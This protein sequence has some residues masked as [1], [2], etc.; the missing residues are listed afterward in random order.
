MF[1]TKSRGAEETKNERDEQDENDHGPVVGHGAV[2]VMLNMASQRQ[3][4][5]RWRSR[6]PKRANAWHQ[7]VPVLRSVVGWDSGASGADSRNGVVQA[8]AE[9]KHQEDAGNEVARSSASEGCA[10]HGSLAREHRD[11]HGAGDDRD[12]TS[13]PANP[14]CALLRPMASETKPTQMF[15]AIAATLFQV[16]RVTD[17]GG[18]EAIALEPGRNPGVHA[19]DAEL[20]NEVGGPDSAGGDDELAGEQ[21]RGAGLGGLGRNDQ[22][23]GIEVNVDVTRGLD[24]LLE[25]SDGLVLLIMVGIPVRGLVHRKEQDDAVDNRQGADQ[26]QTRQFWTAVAPVASVI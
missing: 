12:D 17:S 9:E 16:C 2:D 1:F 19:I 25:T 14:Q 3:H 23:V 10:I 20:A 5:E 21:N 8:E 4:P 6:P 18:G 7:E 22:Q 15:D 13:D 11:E 26:I 24:D